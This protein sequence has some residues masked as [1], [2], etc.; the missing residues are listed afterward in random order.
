MLINGDAQRNGFASGGELE[1][2]LLGR[3]AVK[4]RNFYLTTM[5]APA[6]RV[7]VRQGR[8]AIC[9]GGLRTCQAD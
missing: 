4:K 3:P 8:I 1:L 6:L 7:L 9:Q 2:R 5:L